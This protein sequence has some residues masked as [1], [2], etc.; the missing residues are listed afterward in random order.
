MGKKINAVYRLVDEKFSRN[1]YNYHSHDEFEI[2]Y[3]HSGNCKY[4]IGNQIYHLQEDDM[5]IMNG[6]TLHYA[7]PDPGAAYE[8]SVVEFSPEWLRP[9]LD[10]LNVPELLT[11]FNKLRNSLIRGVDKKKLKEIQELIQKIAVIDL[12][13][14]DL[15][16]QSFEN[17]IKEGEVSTLLTQ[18]LFR[19]YEL[20]KLKLT[21]IPSATSE[22]SIHVNRIIGW[23]DENFHSDISLDC[24]A[25]N[26]NISK[27]YMSRIFKDVTGYTIMQY[28]MCCRINRAKY[29]LEIHCDK[30]I[31]EVALESGFENSSHFSRAFRKQVKITPSEYR[32][33]RAGN[34]DLDTK[35]IRYI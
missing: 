10:S 31:L 21:V 17:R 11:P 32:N 19:I 15:S 14:E 12:N 35:N 26:L 28:L 25:D 4:M 7:K 20:S 1:N 34:Y 33:R 24:I 5:I 18:L 13:K 23:I 3:F 29:L 6:L 16:E 22:K 27:Y 9:V 2:Y 8:R 30:T